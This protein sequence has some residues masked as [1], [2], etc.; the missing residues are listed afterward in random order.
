MLNSQEEVTTF[1]LSKIT[2]ETA[3]HDDDDKSRDNKK[4]DGQEEGVAKAV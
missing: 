4:G 3:K 2:I 1:M